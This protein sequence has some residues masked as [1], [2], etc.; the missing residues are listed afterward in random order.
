MTCIV[1][2]TTPTQNTPLHNQLFVQNNG[3][4]SMFPSTR[5]QN[6]RRLGSFSFNVAF[7]VELVHVFFSCPRIKSSRLGNGQIVLCCSFETKRKSHK[8]QEC[9]WNQWHVSYNCESVYPVLTTLPGYLNSLLRTNA[10]PT[11]VS[12]FS[13]MRYV[14]ERQS[15][16]RITFKSSG[17]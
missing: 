14:A 7:L 13:A 9:T 12:F 2:Q 8:T 1:K 16:G 15:S 5:L 11:V 17:N 10:S 3:F 6:T 4:N